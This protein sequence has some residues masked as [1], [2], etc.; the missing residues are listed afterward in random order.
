MNEDWTHPDSGRIYREEDPAVRFIKLA[1]ALRRECEDFIYHY[2]QRMAGRDYL[3][4]HLTWQSDPDRIARSMGHTIK[5]LDEAYTAVTVN[6]YLHEYGLGKQDDE[7]QRKYG[8]LP[9]RP[10]TGPA[11]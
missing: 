7:W 11:A 9:P 3:G 8:D 1:H 5:A 4:Q 6:R 2:D 10:D